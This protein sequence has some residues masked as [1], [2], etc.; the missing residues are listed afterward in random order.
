MS[1]FLINFIKK[2]TLTQL[3][4]CEFCEDLFHRHLRKTTCDTIVN[5]LQ[6]DF[7]K[8]SSFSN[9]RWTQA[10]PKNIFQE[11]ILHIQPKRK[12][13]ESSWGDEG[14]SAEKEDFSF[15]GDTCK[16]STF[17]TVVT[18]ILCYETHYVFF[19]SCQ[20]LLQNLVSVFIE[21]YVLF[22]IVFT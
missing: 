7:V 19:I 6:S 10:Y 3:L 11:E 13:F 9:F 14:K 18:V 17:V 22:Q 2:E 1:L 5:F 4:P 12:D 8:I 21:P 16:C 20:I 15:V